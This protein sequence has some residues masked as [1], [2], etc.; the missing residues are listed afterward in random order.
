MFLRHHHRIHNCLIFTRFKLLFLS[1]HSSVSPL[2]LLF[3]PEYHP[4]AGGAELIAQRQGESEA[5]AEEQ[6]DQGCNNRSRRK[7]R[8]SLAISQIINSRPWSRDLENALHPHTSALST[9]AVVEILERVKLPSKSLQFF[10]WVQDKRFSHNE[11]TYFKMIE[12]LGRS[13]N[14]NAARNL[15]MG[16]PSH[17][18]QWEDRFFNS[19]MRSYANAGLFQESI[20]L[21]QKMKELGVSPSVYTFNTIFSILLRRGRTNMVRGL[22]DE[23]LRSGVSP[24][25]FTFNILIRG[26]CLN[27]MVDEGFRLFNEMVKQGCTPDMVTYNTLIDGLCRSGKVAKGHNLMRAMRRKGGEL[28]PNVVSYTTLIRG[29]CENQSIGNALELFDEMVEQGL[30]P[31]EI[32]YNTLIQGLCEARKLDKIKEILK[33]VMDSG[34]FKPDTCT[35]NTLI[36]AHCNAGKLNEAVMI[37]GKLSE[38]GVQPDSAT[39]SV[40]IRNLCVRCEFQKAEEF[41]DEVIRSKVLI[42]AE[43]CVPLVASYNPVL[44]YFCENG[45]AEKAERLFRQLLKRGT[46]DPCTF[47][48]LILGQ[49]KEGRPEAGYELLVLMLRRDFVPD[50]ETYSTLINGFIKKDDPVYAHK[51]LQKML[52]SEHVP[53]TSTFHQICSALVAAGNVVDAASVMRMMIDKKIRQNINLSTDVVAGLFAKGHGHDALEVVRALY[54]SGYSVKLESIVDLLICKSKFSEAQVILMFGLNHDHEFGRE[55]CGRVIT[56]LCKNAK[57]EEAF[58]LFY[59]IIENGELSSMT[60][61][62]HLAISLEIQEKSNE[63]AFVSKRMVRGYVTAA[64]DDP[65]YK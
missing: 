49:C 61:I 25:V 5:E 28:I 52:K 44:E 59:E 51:T 42:Q 24:D 14:L 12:V 58:S 11:K 41:V 20:K 37:F 53:R 46:Q 35:F 15:L 18:V 8:I 4:K 62:K 34:S 65:K 21:F 36:N 54:D 9:T 33:D 13:R 40:L 39:Y 2:S 60:S 50:L 6:R 22:Y 47:R 56:G 16:M 17:G 26:F 31:N 38:L 45:K 48:T 30:K 10:K 63:A 27:S 57:A 29:Y 7:R 23:M 43:G 3:A 32:T 55:V 64:N 1:Y 19:L